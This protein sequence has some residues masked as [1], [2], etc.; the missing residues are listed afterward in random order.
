MIENGLNHDVWMNRF[1]L[2]NGIAFYLTWLSLAT[3]LN[4]AIFLTYEASVEV[5][6]SSTVALIAILIIIVAYFVVEN[7]VWPRLVNNTV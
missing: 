7:F 2:Q 5:S 1:I 4:F 6:I 3:N